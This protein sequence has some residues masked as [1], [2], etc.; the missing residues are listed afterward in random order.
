MNECSKTLSESL[1]YPPVSSVAEWG[2]QQVED[3]G[4][5][6]FNEFSI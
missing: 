6:I 1:R 4:L 2:L 5:W 3:F